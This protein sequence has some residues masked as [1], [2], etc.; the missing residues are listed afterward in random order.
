MR[1]IVLYTLTT[2][3]GAVDDPRRYFPDADPQL[4]APP[5]FDEVMGGLEAEVIG[6]QDAV[7]IG[8][9]TFDEWSRF[10]PTSTEQP[11]ADFINGVRKHV[12]TSTPLDRE[13]GPAEVMSGPL[14]DIVADLRARPGRDIGVHGSIRL[15]QALLGQGL[16]DEL[17]LITAPV[18]DPLG[19]RLFG[20]AEELR[21]L[22][23]ASATPTPSGAVW[24]VYTQ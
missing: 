13:W 16:F 15:T 17:H 14:A 3:D 23:L 12:V 10:W 11:F 8:R 6:N 9:N 20:T 18:V 1:R 22:R 21:R 7:L 5:A 2:L 4:P 24:L 19:R